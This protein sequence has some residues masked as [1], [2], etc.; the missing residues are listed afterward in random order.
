MYRGEESAD[1]DAGDKQ[2]EADEEVQSDDETKDSPTRRQIIQQ[3]VVK[4]LL[5]TLVC[6]IIS[7]PMVD[8]VSSFSAV[9]QA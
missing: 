6:A 8:A 3:A 1:E 7:D 4:L 2:G 9:R 5:G